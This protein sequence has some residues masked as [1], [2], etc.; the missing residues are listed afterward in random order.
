MVI[1]LIAYV[2]GQTRSQ[3][4]QIWIELTLENRL[5]SI[6]LAIAIFSLSGSC[7]S[8]MAL[9]CSSFLWAKYLFDA[10]IQRYLLL[11]VFNHKFV[12]FPFPGSYDSIML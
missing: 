6:C 5:F 12:P 1:Q 11:R 2:Q 3:K 7:R 9:C 10:L 8:R 4:K